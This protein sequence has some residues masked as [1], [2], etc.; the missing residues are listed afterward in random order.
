VGAPNRRLAVIALAIL[1]AACGGPAR[2][3]KAQPDVVL[4]TL[5]TTRADHMSA[6][7]YPRETTPHLDTLADDAVRFD[8]AY[9]VT[10]WTLPSHASIFTGKF[11]SA[12]GAQYDPHGPLS[13][14]QE[15][16]IKGPRA[17][18]RIRARPLSDREVTLAAVLEA[19]GYAT[20]AVV[21]GPWMKRV[22]GLDV[23][24]AHYDDRNFAVLNRL[25]ELNGRPAEDVSDAAIAFVDQHQDEP[26]FLF[27]NYYD[28][29]APLL[30]PPSHLSRF[31]PGD[32]PKTPTLEYQLASYDAEIHYM[33][34]HVGRLLDHL[35]RRGL[36]EDAWIIVV[37]DHGE[38]MGDGGL[39]GHG[40]SL[41]QA[42]IHIPLIIKEPGT[43][44][45]RGVDDTKVQQV[46]LMPTLL[47]RLG[48]PLP[49]NLQGGALPDPGH[50]VIAEVYPLL[51]ANPT[52]KGW[53]QRGDWQVLIDGERKLAWSSRGTHALYDLSVDPEETRNLWDPE[54][55]ASQAMADKLAR[56]LEALPE[57]GDLGEIGEVDDETRALLESLGYVG[58]AEEP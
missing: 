2:A 6:Y 14:T 12:H 46:D 23:G 52:S 15:G 25:G 33:D 47:T 13:L 41:S 54:D 20:G 56:Y 36:Y 44:R 31:W 53:R 27:L 45:P 55:P 32:P 18:S 5:D 38:L 19:S 7:G 57:P 22:F 35:R 51:A 43:D 11:P 17:W 29:H 39:F 49:P 40:D 34:H 3:P 30:P 10:S 26:F 42:E 4:I 9:A 50:P 8:S 48:L 1:L 24:F 58:D 28:P 16:G 21:A 37:A